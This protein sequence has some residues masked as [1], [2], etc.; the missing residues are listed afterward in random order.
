[1]ITFYITMWT[2]DIFAL[3]LICVRSVLPS[4]AQC[5][6]HI[7]LPLRSHRSA[8]TSSGRKINCCCC[9]VL[10]LRG[11]TPGCL[12]ANRPTTKFSPFF[13]PLPPPPRKR[14]NINN[15]LRC[16]ERNALILSRIM[17]E[18]VVMF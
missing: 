6:V 14:I 12:A 17:P 10:A 3:Q 8:P 15:Q 16:M 1:M 9:Y 5:F 2:S 18:T 4:K 13:S 11:K 7:S